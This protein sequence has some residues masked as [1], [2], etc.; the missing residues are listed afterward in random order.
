MARTVWKQTIALSPAQTIQLPKDAI[1]RKVAYQN[2]ELQLWFEFHL[3]NQDELV[4]R[5]LQIT[6]TGYAELPDDPDFVSYIDT[7]LDGPYV[8]HLYERVTL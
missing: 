5:H 7:I 1:L 8:W 4:D 6:G 3:E 2:F